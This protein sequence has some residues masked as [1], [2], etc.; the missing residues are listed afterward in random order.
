[1]V[2]LVV[3]CV[4]DHESTRIFAWVVGYFFDHGRRGITQNLCYEM[5]LGLWALVVAFYRQ[6]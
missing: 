5:E 3:L 6:N 2:V 4:A 1:M